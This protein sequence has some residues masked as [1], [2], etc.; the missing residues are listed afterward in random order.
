MAGKSNT[1]ATFFAQK[2]LLGK[3]HTSNLKTD[4][5]ELIGSNIQAA[6]SL[7]FGQAIPESPEQTLYLMQSAS[8][9]GPATVEY[10][11]FALNALTGTTYDANETNPDGGS[12]TDSGE[13]SQISGVH[14]YKF[15]FRSDYTS[16]SSNPKKNNGDFNDNKIVHETL[17]RV[18]LIPPFFSQTAPNPYIVKIYKD[19][20]SGG[21]GDEIPLLDNV[22]WNVDFYNGILFLQDFNASKIPA[23]AKA[24]AYVGDFADKGFFENSLSGSLQQLTDG[25]SYLVA[26]SNITITSASNGQVTISSSGGA[27]GTPGGANTQ[28]QFNDAGSF[29]GDAD[30]TYNKTTNALQSAGF[31]TASLGFS[32]SLTKLADGT[33]YI[34]SST[35]I[36]VVSASNGAITLKVNKEM[37]FNEL[38][39]GNATG[40]NTLFT[41]ANTPFASNEISI[42]VNGQLQTP[43]DLTDFQDYSVTGSNVYFTTGSVPPQGSLVTAMYNKVVS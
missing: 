23:H 4:G 5:E 25:N 36:N 8:N 22:D 31:I 30:L 29:G 7:L 40:T 9:G 15:V 16:N 43:P 27:G 11:H 38:L 3:A 41:L 26:G 21:I 34:Q 33:S 19:N 10:I 32:G 20:G 42:F 24:F 13:S 2:K 6:S 37:V 1:S 14:T 35:G 28:L 17:G 39:G 18:Q 12:G